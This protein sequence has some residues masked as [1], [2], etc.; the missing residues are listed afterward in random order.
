VRTVHEVGGRREDAP[1]VTEGEM[2]RR[3]RRRS[4]VILHFIC[5]I[6]FLLSIIQG[7]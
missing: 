4:S 2:R 5:L 3:R 6:L 7:N 1:L